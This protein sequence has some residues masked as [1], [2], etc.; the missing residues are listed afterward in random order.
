MRK[1]N[2]EVPLILAGAGGHARVLL[3]TLLQMGRRVDGFVDPDTSRVELLGIPYLGGDDAVFG[4]DRADVLLINGVGSVASCTNRL[5]VYE[6]FRKRG[7]HFASV[8]HPG[9]IIAPEVQLADGVQIMAGAIIQTGCIVEENCIINT[10]ARVDHDCVIEPHAHVAP[11][12]V[13]SGGV[14]VGARA[15]VGT[16]AIAIQGVRIG[17]DSIV[18]AGAVVLSDV[19]ES[20]TV[21]GVP[22]RPIQV[23]A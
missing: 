12:A 10:G 2:I 9:A 13:L 20:C 15:H 3:S 16:G 7:Y 14:H 6:S 8:I 23:K 19:P 22:A 4:Y 5:R 18:G 1:P 11:G 17:A 21:V